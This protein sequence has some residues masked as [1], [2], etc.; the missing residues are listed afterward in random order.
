MRELRQ[1]LNDSLARN[2][3][4]E[5][6]LQRS[7]HQNSVL[8]RKCQETLCLLDNAEATVIERS[9]KLKETSKKY[10]DLYA[11]C[12]RLYTNNRN[13]EQEIEFLKSTNIKINSELKTRVTQLNKFT[14]EIARQTQRVNTSAIR[15]DEYFKREFAGLAKEMR[16]WSF[17]YFPPH[18]DARDLASGLWD[19]IREIAG[20]TYLHEISENHTADRRLVCGLLA[21]RLRKELFDPFLLGL[22]SEEFARFES[23]LE[24]TG[25]KIGPPR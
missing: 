15:D 18:P 2:S 6:E 8:D 17:S 11:E 4:L 25:K 13:Q 5:T 10:H 12:K 19:E 1:R 24:K 3:D 21:N 7:E 20:G 14:G 9:T 22:L 16:D 23:V